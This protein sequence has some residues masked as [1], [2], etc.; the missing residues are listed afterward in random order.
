MINQLKSAFK[1][2]LLKAFFYG[3][4]QLNQMKIIQINQISVQKNFNEP[5]AN[6]KD[7]HET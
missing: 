5:I 1:F 2:S 7:L 4:H 6:F 3:N